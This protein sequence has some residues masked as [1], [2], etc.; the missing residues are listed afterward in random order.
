MPWY[1]FALVDEPP[2]VRLGRGLRG[3]LAARRLPAGFA[4]VER[5]ADVPPA[6]FDT[7]RTHD[8]VVARLAAA[9]PAILPVRFGTLLELEEMDEALADREPEIV[10]AFDRV[11]GRV[12]FTWR[13]QGARRLVAEARRAKAA[14]AG[15]AGA[16]GVDYLRRAAAKAAP[17]AAFRA[18]REQLRPLL[19]AERYQAATAS[20]PHALYHLVDRGRVS[21]YS[22]IARTLASSSPALRLSG[23]FPPFAFTPEL[24]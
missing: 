1:V 14:A 21:R 7:L 3:S 16:P 19:A 20:L 24:L 17:P 22:L 2:A 18:V 9:V 5:R 15:D 13:A 12:Q 8:A 11:R 23:P 6:E 4:I 10:E